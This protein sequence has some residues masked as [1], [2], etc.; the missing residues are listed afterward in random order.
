MHKG[1]RDTKDY[2]A[3]TYRWPRDACVCRGA[4]DPFDTC[5]DTL[6]CILTL[7]LQVIMSG[8]IDYFQ[9]EEGGMLPCS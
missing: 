1:L 3:R 8:S 2:E 5:A 7:L 9:R 4:N 6:I